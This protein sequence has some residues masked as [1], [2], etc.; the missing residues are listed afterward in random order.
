MEIQGL[1]SKLINATLA[2]IFA[3]LV[4]YILIIGNSILLPLAIAVVIWYLIVR[5][6]ALFQQIPFTHF[7]LPF[8]FAFILSLIASTFV[9]Y[10]F[11]TLVTSSIYG[12]INDAP[13]YQEKLN[14]AL[15]YFNHLTG[16]KF[17]YAQL[18]EQFSLTSFFSNVALTIT[19][20]ASSLVLIIAYVLFLLLEYKT[21]DYK[22]RAICA[23]NN[24]YEQASEIV[25]KIIGDINIYMKAKTAM[26]LLTGASSY[27]VLF[28]FGI[29]FASFWA[30]LIFVLNY[31]PTIGSII[32]V[33]FI[34]LAITIQFT[35]LTMFLVLAGL[36]IAIQFIVGNLLEPRYMG[37]N[38]NLSPLVIMLSLA[39]WSSIWGVIGMFLCV[40]LMTI[41][42]II[43]SKF[44]STRHFAIMLSSDADF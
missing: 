2:L 39:F 9:L 24:S 15:N 19:N 44:D 14:L 37:K 32:A 8:W 23:A 30:L 38:L 25:D 40:P 1:N 5:M 18:F 41:L 13:K 35:S 11:M 21:F 6:V 17:Q 4:V 27:I 36:L 29:N 10:M 34:L 31:I 42:N 22:L 43:L 7:E 26:S 12:I 33:V 16:A 20:L 28:A 3:A